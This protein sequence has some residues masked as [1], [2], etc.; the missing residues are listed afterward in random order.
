MTQNKFQLL[1]IDLFLETVGSTYSS[2][3][4]REHDPIFVRLLDGKYSGWTVQLD[5]FSTEGDNINFA[6]EI[7]LVPKT[8]T[9]DQI[10]ETF[11]DLAAYIQT[12]FLEIVEEQVKVFNQNLDIDLNK[13]ETE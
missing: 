3:K 9:E 10:S 4:T 6:V 12:I 2:G 11:D 1:P 5:D 7:V 13:L 8:V